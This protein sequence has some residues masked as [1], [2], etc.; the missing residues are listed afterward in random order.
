M[1]PSDLVS[2][3]KRGV[4]EGAA[5]GKCVAVKAA[6]GAVV[7]AVEVGT[8]AAVGEQPAPPSA[9]RDRRYAQIAMRNLG[10]IFCITVI[11][12]IVIHCEGVKRAV[13]CVG[14]SIGVHC[15]A[16]TPFDRLPQFVPNHRADA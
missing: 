6:V 1:A 10:D 15:R 9:R 13:N 16:V 3:M 4:I 8:V 14:F 2:V 12:A 5:I 7:G 11:G